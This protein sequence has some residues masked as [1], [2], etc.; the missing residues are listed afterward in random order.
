VHAY[1]PIRREVSYSHSE[2]QNESTRNIQ[3]WLVIKQGVDSGL[4]G[5]G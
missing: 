3:A 1:Q 2:W 4:M 5:P